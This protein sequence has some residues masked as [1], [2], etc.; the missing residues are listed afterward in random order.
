MRIWIRN[1]ALFFANLRIAD[2][3]IKEI[4][5][6]AIFGLII[7]NL[8]ICQL[9]SVAHLKNLRFAICGRTKKI[10]VHTSERYYCEKK[11]GD[12][13]VWRVYSMKKTGG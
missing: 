3:D 5:R 13:G 11:I 4:C 1:T 10:C 8:R 2:S 9:R 12:R 6:F 7:A